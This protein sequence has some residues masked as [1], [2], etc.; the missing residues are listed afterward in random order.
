[1]R[2]TPA[3]VLGLW[4]R[5]GGLRRG[6]ESDM[7]AGSTAG[8]CA[9]K[10]TT[11]MR[12][13]YPAA[14]AARSPHAITPRLHIV[15]DLVAQLWR[16]IALLEGPLWCSKMD[17]QQAKEAWW[18]ACACGQA[19]RSARMQMQRLLGSPSSPGQWLLTSNPSILK[20]Y[21]AGYG[22]G[23]SKSGPCAALWL[24]PLLLPPTH[25]MKACL[26]PRV[27]LT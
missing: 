10:G 19:I 23:E 20:A 9:T 27:P 25:V 22:Q 11:L 18:D 13:F 2:H 26:P 4:G 1:M 24:L 7:S 16:H 21:C 12:Q 15:D 6:P 3:H 14:P 5:S 17:T 8:P